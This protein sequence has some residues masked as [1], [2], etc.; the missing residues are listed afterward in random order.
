MKILPQQVSKLKSGRKKNGNDE[1][2]TDWVIE[3]DDD[4]GAAAAVGTVASFSNSL[5]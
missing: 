3:G 1:E 5:A 2:N 4:M